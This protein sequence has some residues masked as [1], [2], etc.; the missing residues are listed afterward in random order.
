MKHGHPLY[1]S[2]LGLSL[3][4]MLGLAHAAD[5]GDISQLL[6][7]GKLAEAQTRVERLLAAQP[8]DPQLRLYKG[9]IQRETGRANEALATFSKLSE[10]HPELPEPYNNLAVIYAAQGQ[11]D[12]ARVVL[13][14]ALRTHPS[15]ATA[16][17]N[18]TDVYARLASQAYSKALQLDGSA[19]APARLA[20]IRDLAPVG[21]AAR[22]VTLAAAPVPPPATAPA[23]VKP[24]APPAPAPAVAVAPAPAPTTARTAP[25]PVAAA[26]DGAREV[27]QAVRA[28]AQAWSER[29]MTRYLAAYDATFETPGRQARSAWE[30]DRRARILSKSRITV[31]LMDL[32]IT[33]Q[34]QRAVAKFRQD[35]KA[36]ALAILSRKTLEL[37]RSGNRWLIVKESSGG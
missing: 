10:D 22:P 34:G 16:H 19:P 20:M 29:D 30:Q 18:L 2:L 32:Q 7:E 28:W 17:D 5:H 4:G 24:P 37:V 1:R 26:T 13:E 11:Y 27:E 33:V 9:V 15:Y 31:Q 6:R 8:R 21:A 23:A 36:D 12:K 35:Y 25:P 3:A 14:K